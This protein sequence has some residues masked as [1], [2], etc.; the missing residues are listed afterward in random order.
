[1]GR[2]ILH[3]DM[4]AFYA[5]CEC[6][7]RP[8]I[9]NLPVAVGGDPEARHGIILAKNQKAKIAG[10]KTG[11]ALWEAR[12]RCPQLVIVPPNYSLY[13]RYS[14][15]AREIYEEYTN[16]VEPFG[17][18][19]AWLDVGGSRLIHGEGGKIAN[20]LRKRITRELGITASIGVSYNKVFAKLGSDMNKPN[21]L[22]VITQDNYK[23]KV[24]PLPVGDLL[25]VGPATKRKLWSLG[26]DTIGR[27][28]NMPSDSLRRNFGKWGLMLHLFANGKDE[29]PVARQDI[30]SQIKGIGNSS[31]TPRDLEN[32]EDVK[33][34]YYVLCESVAERLREHGFRARTVQISVRDKDLI[35]FVRQGKLPK[36]TNLSTELCKKAMELFCANYG[37]DKPIRS[38]GIRATDLI[39]ICDEIQLSFIED[40]E[41]L[42]RMER[43]EATIDDLRR[44]FGH[45]AVSR[46]SLLGDQKLNAINPKDDHVIFPVGYFNERLPV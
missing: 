13:M 44:R 26:V 2:T 19:E 43:L 4:D 42:T 23:E 28:A 31:T 38:I 27:L 46:A 14:K 41:K 5:S 17:L 16:Q 22:A 3:C 39:P 30:E 32:N 40:K 35:S 9:R 33:L 18:D 34:V 6:F 7:Y 21:G 25:Y 12:S 10:V 1:M 45:Y 20:E 8:E 37:W 29:S 15:M 11:S 24:W 36:A